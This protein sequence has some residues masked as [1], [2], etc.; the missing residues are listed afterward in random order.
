[1]KQKQLVILGNGGA[2][3]NAVKAI[4]ST[5]YTGRILQVSDTTGSA[6]NPM[7]SPY[8]LKGIIDWDDCFPFGVDFYKIFD[9]N[10]HF[11]VSIE[12]LDAIN[13][14]V[15][16]SDNKILEY[17]RCLIATGAS[18]IIPPI[19]G[20]NGS[21]KSLTL[22][23]AKDT[24][25]IEKALNSANKV[26]II[27]AS[28][29]GVKLAEILSKNNIRTI[30]LDIVPQVLPKGAHPKTALSLEKY[31]TEHNIE[32][33]LGCTL[34]HLEEGSKDAVCYF[35]GEIKEET[36]FVAV[37]AGI[38]PNTDFIDRS[39]VN[40]G[41]AIQVDQMMRTSADG[42][43]AAGDV[44]QGMNRQT[45]KNEYLGTWGNACFQGR[46]AGLNM[47]GKYNTYAGTVPQYISPFFDWTYAQ[48]GDINRDGEET[49][50]LIEGD[51]FN[52]P[53][54]LLVFEKDILVGANLINR[55]NDVGITRNAII[56]MLS[57]DEFL[58]KMYG[59]PFFN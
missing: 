42:L 18:P 12:S 26:I 17:D 49:E 13:K 53:Y 21:S 4:R 50:I 36:D 30:L 57:K 46:T 37:C 44:C 45:G 24:K 43:Y 35:P 48:I 9:V 28:L 47:A 31:L 51:P 2:A 52:G 27:G 58:S 32:L 38:K 20:L 59:F 54:R 6:F 16:L 34:E 14:R 1:L 19:S 22:R 23:T 25:N 11:G 8:Y 29:I 10:C 41:E 33:R 7:L 3:I 15:Y 40:M 39:Q 55:E 56:R 5:G